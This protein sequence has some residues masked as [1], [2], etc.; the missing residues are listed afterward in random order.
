MTD[1]Q[2]IRRILEAPVT[3][4]AASGVIRQPVTAAR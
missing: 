2:Q 1:P 3:K 4:P